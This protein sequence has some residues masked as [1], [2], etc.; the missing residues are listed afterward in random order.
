MMNLINEIKKANS[1]VLLG[2]VK[3]DG[4]CIGAVTAMYSYI[5]N[6][7]NNKSVDMVLDVFIDNYSMINAVKKIQS[8]SNKNS[9]D[10]CICL[11]V[12]NK[13][14][15]GTYSKYVDISKRCIVVD[16]HITN[17]NFA[18][19]IYLDPTASSTC[20]LLFDLFDKNYISKDTAVSLFTGLITD[21]GVFR[22][23]CTTDRSF[24]MAAA[25]CEYDIDRAKI[26]EE[27]FYNKSDKVNRFISKCVLNRKLI[28][29]NKTIYTIVSKEMMIENDITNTEFEGIVEA[30]RNT[31]GVEVAIFA[32]EKSE[33]CYKV[34]M[35][36]KEKVDVSRICQKFDGGGHIKAAGCTLKGNFDE[37]FSELLNEVKKS[38]EY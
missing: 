18:D 37:L 15:L 29:N 9:Y 24:K 34:S 31:I 4:D 5:K 17:D 27:S 19:K 30:L 12:A 33:K 11:D 3:P 28:H 16:H 1:V 2:H 22:Y 6:I 35:R 21:T 13:E 20:E 25:L 8:K 32:Y 14:R 7:D 23:S 38:Y 26:I 36:A 10:L